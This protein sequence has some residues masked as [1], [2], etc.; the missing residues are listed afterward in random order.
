ME[1]H[2][3]ALAGWCDSEHRQQVRMIGELD[4]LVGH[5]VD[6]AVIGGEHHQSAPARGQ[7]AK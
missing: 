7:G 6:V 4:C 1:V 3:A 5:G 2:G